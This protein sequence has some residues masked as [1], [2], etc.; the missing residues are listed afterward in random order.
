M[1]TSGGQPRNDPSPLVGEGGPAEQ[2]RMRGLSELSGR[3]RRLQR[4]GPSTPHPSA[5]PPPSPA[6]GGRHRRVLQ[7]SDRNCD[8]RDVSI[9]PAWQGRKTRKGAPTRRPAAIVQKLDNRAAGRSVAE[10]YCLA[11]CGA[12]VRATA[13]L[14]QAP[15]RVSSMAFVLVKAVSAPTLAATGLQAPDE[16]VSDFAPLPTPA[17]ASQA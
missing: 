4:R 14:L 9:L 5:S 6:R 12:A 2:G 11:S 7:A 8:F 10:A 13:T 17:S 16:K 15:R 1:H 3:R